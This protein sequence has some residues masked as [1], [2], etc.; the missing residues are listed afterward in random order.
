MGVNKNET[1]SNTYKKII[2]LAKAYGAVHLILFGSS[3][4]DTSKAN[5]IDIACDGVNGW[6]LYSLAAKLEEELHVHF[7][8]VPLNPPYRFTKFIEH[9][10]RVIL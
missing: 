4:E 2:T 7:D 1:H 8:I 10:G 3:L 9:K 5:D 6:S